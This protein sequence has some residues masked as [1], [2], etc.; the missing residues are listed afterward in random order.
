MSFTFVDDSLKHGKHILLDPLLWGARY[1]PDD[2][3]AYY[4]RL[5]S[6]GKT[7]TIMYMQSNLKHVKA[8]NLVESWEVIESLYWEYAHFRINSGLDSKLADL[9]KEVYVCLVFHKDMPA[10]ADITR[11]DFRYKAKFVP[12]NDKLLIKGCLAVVKHI[13]V[14]A[15]FS[16]KALDKLYAGRKEALI[17]TVELYKQRRGQLCNV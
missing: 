15:D 9:A 12:P 10:D 16:R 13:G 14:Y 7:Y 2:V 6:V 11:N 1:L 5:H 8:E 4:D 17:Q 3:E